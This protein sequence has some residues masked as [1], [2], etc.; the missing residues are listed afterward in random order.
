MR[1]AL[2]AVAL[3]VLSLPTTSDFATQTQAAGGSWTDQRVLFL[4][5]TVSGSSIVIQSAVTGIISGTFSGTFVSTGVTTVDLTTGMATYQATDYCFCSVGKQTGLITFAETGKVV[6][7]S[8]PGIGSLT[9]VATI[10]PSETA[11]KGLTGQITL[12]GTAN[13][14]TFLTF[15]SYAGSISSH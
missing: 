3:I 6:P 5:Q 8:T 15:G 7:T 11:I 13:G 14:I 1:I 4:S 2:F 12:T 10:V 9:S